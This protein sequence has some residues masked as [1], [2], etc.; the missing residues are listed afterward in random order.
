MGIGSLFKAK[1]QKN[2]GAPENPPTVGTGENARTINPEMPVEVWANYSDM[3]FSGKLAECSEERLTVAKIAGEPA[4]SRLNVGDAV[5]VRGYDAKMEPFSLWAKVESSFTTECVMGALEPVVYDDRR[6][7]VR[8]PLTPPAKIH[9]M[10]DTRLNEPQRCRL[11]NISTGGACIISVF[12]YELE[13]TLKLR[14][15]LVESSEHI[16]SYQCKVVRVTQRPDGQFEYGLLFAPL[17][18]QTLDDL[19]Q[20]IKTIHAEARRRVMA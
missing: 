16:S 8:Y 2:D 9:A 19:M 17:Q 15:K 14:V 3:L 11:V 18:Q 20:D 10:D 12:A 1:A 13:Q 7:S 4:F 6:K 5:L